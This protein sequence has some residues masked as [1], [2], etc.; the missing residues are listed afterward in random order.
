M[1][2]FIKGLSVTNTSKDTKSNQDKVMNSETNKTQKERY[3]MAM[4]FITINTNEWE[5]LSKADCMKLISDGARFLIEDGLHKNFPISAVT[6]FLLGVFHGWYN[7]GL[8]NVD[9]I[10][11]IFSYSVK[12]EPAKGMRLENGDIVFDPRSVDTFNTLFSELLWK[13][14]Y[15]KGFIANLGSKDILKRRLMVYGL[16]ELKPLSSL[17]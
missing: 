4:S 15:D 11:D 5:T 8:V 6:S 16:V 14:T 7:A 3:S 1:D 13:A 17:L 10:D 9:W 2:M 12:T